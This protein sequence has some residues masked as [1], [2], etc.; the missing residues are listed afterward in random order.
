MVYLFGYSKYTVPVKYRTVK[1]NS[2]ANLLL[3]LEKENILQRLLFKHFLIAFLNSNNNNNN[4]NNRIF[5]KA[6]FH[7]VL[8]AL[9]TI[10]IEIEVEELK[11]TS[12]H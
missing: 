12:L 10:K 3:Y 5:L 2:S 7:G 9:Y 11:V 1:P 4:N 6:P 8:L